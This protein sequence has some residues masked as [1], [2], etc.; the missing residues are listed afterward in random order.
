MKNF[1]Y[2]KD[3]LEKQGK[4]VSWLAKETG[5]S[6][7]YVSK[8]LNNKVTE[9]GSAKIQAIHQVLNIIEEPLEYEKNA[10][11][12]DVNS[13]SI[14]K[15]IYVA[16][17]CINSSYD[18]FIL[19]NSKNINK[20]I[21][22][23]R[24]YDYLNFS[25]SKVLVVNEAELKKA[26]AKTVYTKMIAFNN[27]FDFLKGLNIVNESLSDENVLQF[28]NIRNK[29]VLLLSNNQD[30]LSILLN[31]LKLKT[32]YLVDDFSIFKEVNNNSNSLINNQLSILDKIYQSCQNSR[33]Y[34]IGNEY[35]SF[36]QDSDISDLKNGLVNIKEYLDLFDLVYVINFED[37]S[38]VSKQLAMR[39]SKIIKL[40][41]EKHYALDGEDI[42]ALATQIIENMEDI[43]K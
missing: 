35:L 22:L 4:S 38:E 12:I 33:Y 18:I 8:L 21:N 3:A 19:N 17:K 36:K 24:F 29:S 5:V 30:K 6:K 25:N 10:Y 40:A 1:Q 27:E 31:V 15:Y 23:K 7:G 28:R 42:L 13:L 43:K 41:K 32:N 11:L 26:L 34:I 2:I 14:E 16:T 39:N 37:N 9:P 20:E